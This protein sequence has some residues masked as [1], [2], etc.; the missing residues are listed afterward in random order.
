[1]YNKVVVLVL[2][3]VVLVPVVMAA[4]P[5]VVSNP[6]QGYSPNEVALLAAQVTQEVRKSQDEII[7]QV[8]AY[9]DENFMIFD[10][11]MAGVITDIK[12]KVAL[13]AIGA[14][15]IANALV[16]YF[17]MRT[18]K[19]Y[20]YEK[21]LE[22][23]IGK[24]EKNVAS[25]QPDATSQGMQQMAQPSWDVQQ[26]N[27]TLGMQYGQQFASEATQMNAWQSQPAYGGAWQSP[28][29]TQPEYSRT[30]VS[31]EFIN[32]NERIDDPMQSPQWTPER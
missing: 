22:K 31:H 8:N 2:F 25:M 16:A 10:Q 18:M 5:V 9:N 13:G 23:T 17:I 4:D 15:L 1:M 26:P 32:R 7:S 28:V 24:Y 29:Q 20:S 6:S 21:F 19:T 14:A 11:R 27:Q 3:L 12:T 30:P